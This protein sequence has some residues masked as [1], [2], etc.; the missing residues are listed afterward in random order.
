MALDP[1][2]RA[3]LENAL[4]HSFK[5]PELLEEAL[6]HPSYGYE[7][8]QHGPDN[9][10]LEFLGDAVLQL[11][12][13]ESL[14]HRFPSWREGQ[15]TPLR[16]RLVNRQQLHELA[17]RLGLGA[18][19]ILSRG[20]ENNQGRTRPSNLADA[21]EAVLGALFL[22]GGLE[23]ARTTILQ[24]LQEVLERAAADS[25]SNSNPKGALQEQLQTQG[26]APPA[27]TCISEEG[28][29]HARQFVVEVSWKG[30]PLAAGSGASKKEAEAAAATEALQQ[31]QKESSPAP[32]PAPE[33]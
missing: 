5:L 9:Q 30:K 10:R 32:T 29:P 20:E 23:V 6:T 14:Y 21:M 11:V 7:R 16:A 26:D 25:A 18:L 3:A 27:Y 8:R 2:K 12:I 15:L 28:P 17:D 19:L 24:L 31:L 1:E 33:A 13:T 4:G 22:D